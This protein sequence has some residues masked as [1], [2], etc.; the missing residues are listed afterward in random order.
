MAKD[1]HLRNHL[2]VHSLSSDQVFLS[3]RLKT[4]SKFSGWTF[5][6]LPLNCII[7]YFIYLLS[8]AAIGL[9]GPFQFS[10]QF[11]L[12]GLIGHVIGFDHK[13]MK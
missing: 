7:V 8:E 9:V 5:H 13:D 1:S 4:F 6:F 11:F 3:I 12:N 10:F 2:E